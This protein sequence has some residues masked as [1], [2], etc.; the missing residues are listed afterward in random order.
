MKILVVDDDED[1]RVFVQRL[2]ERNGMECATAEDSSA[3]LAL[4]KERDRGY[5]DVI[6]LDVMMPV[7]SGWDLLDELR[8][9]GDETPVIF[10]TARQTVEERVKGLRL[11]ADDYVAKPFDSA[12][13]IARMEAVV[14]RRR[15]LPAIEVGDLRIDLGRRVV[16][17]GE[18]RIETSP[19][20][21]DLLR[22][23][24]ESPG[25]ALSRKDLLQTVWGIE[26][27]PGTNVVEVQISRLR[28][29]IDACGPPMIET[30][31]GKG[32]RLVAAK[33]ESS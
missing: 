8:Q 10:L 1:V 27:D 31:V 5:F 32:Y 11:G 18:R 28:R 6:L 23:L 7:Q 16:E 4:L 19:R 14:R 12:E 33:P 20:E 9:A 30:L 25:R 29:K 3:A 21:F 17:R 2:L 26:F 13:L 15:S 24:A 22:A